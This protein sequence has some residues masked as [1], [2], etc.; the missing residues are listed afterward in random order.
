M[1]VE[2]PEHLTRVTGCELAPQGLPEVDRNVTALAQAEGD[3]RFWKKNSG[4]SEP[5]MT[6]TMEDCCRPSCTNRDWVESKGLTPDGLY[7]AF[8][9]CD[10][11]GVPITEPE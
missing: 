9:T 7:N 2:C 4:G 3:S 8:Y 11:Q 10:T 6:T 5:Y 1:R